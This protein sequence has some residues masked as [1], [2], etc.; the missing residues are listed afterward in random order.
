M[1]ISQNNKL[2]FSFFDREDYKGNEPSFF[3][4]N[5]IE[6]TNLLTENKEVIIKEFSENSNT[7]F[8]PY[9]NQSVVNE[10]NIWKTIAFKAWT[11]NYYKTQ[12]K[13]PKTMEVLNQIPGLMSA[14]INKLEAGGH[15]VPHNGDSNGFY[16]CHF[17]LE[18]PDTLPKTGFKVGGEERSWEKGEL[19]I[20]C[21]AVKHEA[22]NHADKDR[23]ILL[24]DVVRP[25]FKT[26]KT[27]LVHTVTASLFLQG[28]AE[29]MPF[30]YKLP[31]I[32]QGMIHFFA[33]ISSM[34]YIP[35]R[36]TVAKIFS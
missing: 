25:E 31:L 2:W 11:V 5:K 22:W 4:V 23:Y 13:F 26:Q 32:I 10:K 1:S 28:L 29:K 34:I 17:G 36:N 19:L 7:E 24:F 35:L 8:S 12:K 16:R 15:I 6:W 18:I 20:F 27:K 14:S 33:R 21:D 30:L 9:F 3:E